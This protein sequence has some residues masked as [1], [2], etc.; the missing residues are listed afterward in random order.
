MSIHFFQVL[1][2]LFEFLPGFV[3]LTLVQLRLIK[4]LKGLLTHVFKLRFLGLK[5]F[6][7]GLSI[8]KCG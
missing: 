8:E 4:R 7:T 2:I 6:I 1:V 5:F 3:G